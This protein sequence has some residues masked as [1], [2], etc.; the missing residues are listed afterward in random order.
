MKK[1]LFLFSVLAFACKKKEE[2]NPLINVS[3]YPKTIAYYNVDVSTNAQTLRYN[4]NYFYS[5]NNRFD[6]IRIANTLYS[7]NYSQ[8]AT[9]AT[10]RLDY[11]TYYDEI[12][13]DNQYYNLIAY[14][15][16][17]GN[18]DTSKYN[19]AYD[20]ISRFKSISYAHNNSLDNFASTQTYKKDSVFVY[21]NFINRAC[22]TTDT[23]KNATL[24]MSKT[25]PYLLFVKQENNCSSYNLQNILSALPLSSFTN[26]LPSKIISNNTQTDFS[27]QF[28]ATQ[29][30]T[31]AD[32]IIKQRD[33]NTIVSKR[34]IIISY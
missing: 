14:K 19:F 6:S 7:F 33:N 26:K 1:W 11:D 20:S 15:Q 5:S 25:L 24:D 16:I 22:Y 23:I 9:A 12:V 29:R 3:Q 18:N 34:R 8:F 17:L 27:Y 30:L 2:S 4:I 28:D 31:Q 21:S 10:I 32:I 13:Y